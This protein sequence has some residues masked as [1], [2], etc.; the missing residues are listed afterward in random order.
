M[1]SFLHPLFKVIA[2][3]MAV[4][5]AS[6]AAS[7][8]SANGVRKIPHPLPS[9]PGNIFLVG[10]DVNV[11]APPGEV[12][13]WRMHNYD[14]NIIAKGTIRDGRVELGKLPVG[15]YKIVRGA[16]GQYTNRTYIAV[17]EPLQA[18]TPKT[19]PVGIDVGMAWFFPEKQ[20]MKPVA[21]L[22]ELA[23]INRVRDRLLWE[24]MEPKRG[25]FKAHT[26]YDDS[27]EVQSQAGL[28]ILQVCH[29]SAR[30]ATTNQQRFPP[31]LRDIYSFYRET[32]KRWRGEVEAFEPWNEADLNVFGGHTGNEMASFQKAAYLGLKEGNPKVTACM[33][34]F[35]IR[36][37]ETL[38][39]FY[40]NEVWPYYDT[41]NLHHYEPLKNYPSL[42]ADHRA[43]SGGK[44]MWV[45]ECSVHVK[46]RG[47]ERFKELSEA[48]Q[49]KQSEE[50]T[51]TFTLAI[52]EGVQAVFYFVLPHY[53][54]Y[55]IQYGL[56]HPDLCPR[57]GYVALAA[58]GRLLADA[59]PLG[60]VKAKDDSLQAYLFHAKPDGKPS[61]VLV[62]WSENKTNF[63]LPIQ[64]NTCFDHLG[65]KIAVAGK[66]LTIS[67]APVYVVLPTDS[68]LQLS[69]PP[70]PAKR[71]TDKPGTLVLQAL[72]PTNDIVHL[73]SAYQLTAGE[74]K[75]IPIFL[76]NFGTKNR[77]AKW[78]VTAPKDW[79]AEFVSKAEISPG[80]RKEMTLKITPAPNGWTNAQVRITGSFSSKDK[81]VLSMNFIPTPLEAH[82]EAHK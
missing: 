62:L 26:R 16:P 58:V 43:V 32:A 29:V 21:R 57:P 20:K 47:D 46:W 74:T 27:A 36:R 12:S 11:P 75:S 63:A 51:K 59:K 82:N 81:P 22:C 73:K 17:L 53:S 76:Y 18:P 66:T 28:G 77:S 19:S 25:Q 33:N 37:P 80:E 65:R 38:A 7:L 23:G 54:E 2:Y 42:Y 69:P 67:N 70:K 78:K 24:E 71:L 15:Y 35:A 64:P 31:D 34:V 10:E 52:H 40:A 1:R 72:V 4:C 48:E 13:T 49:R 39:D 14:D 30:W 55:R 68:R 79:K 60:R 9:H 50:V 61:D 3:G 41:Y 45:S 8:L 44:P 5:F 6:T 56:L